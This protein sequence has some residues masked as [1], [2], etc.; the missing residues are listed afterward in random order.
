[1]TAS[2]SGA[3]KTI[4]NPGAGSF[5]TLPKP[6]EGEVIAVDPGTRNESGKLI[7]L[8]ANAGDRILFGKWSCTDFRIDGEAPLIKNEPDIMGVVAL[9][10]YNV[11]QGNQILH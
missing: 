10:E 3:R 1:M 7:P 9:D 2:S 4:S 8:D 6:L 11:C 5:A